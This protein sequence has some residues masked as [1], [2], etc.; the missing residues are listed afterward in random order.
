MSKDKGSSVIEVLIVITILVVLMTIVL[1]SLSK[2]NS[3]QSLDK[4]ASLVVSVLDQA[5]SLTLSSKNSSQYGVYLN[6]SSV[7]LF[8]GSTYNSS[9]PLNVVTSLDAKVGIRN[10]SLA[11]GGSSVVFKRL[12]G[13]TN[14]SGTLELFLKDTSTVFRTINISATGV[15][16]TTP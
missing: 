5:R 3:S 12:T 1:I 16:T 14:Q 4:S 13:S 10:I 9:D 7:T 6:S 2:L 8:K 11:G 15:V